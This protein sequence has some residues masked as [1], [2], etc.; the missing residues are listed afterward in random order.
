MNWPGRHSGS[1]AGGVLGR[2]GGAGRPKG[3]W[4]QTVLGGSRLRRRPRAAPESEP[5]NQHWRAALDSPAGF[6]PPTL[7]SSNTRTSEP[8]AGSGARANRAELLP[9]KRPSGR[10]EE[11]DEE[12][13]ETLGSGQR[14]ELEA[15]QIVHLAGEQDNH[16]RNYGYSSNYTN[17]QR[18]HDTAPQSNATLV[19]WPGALASSGGPLLVELDQL[20]QF[21]QTGHPQLSNWGAAFAAGLQ[22][23]RESGS[24]NATTN[25]FDQL[26]TTGGAGSGPILSPFTATAMAGD[27]RELNQLEQS[28]WSLLMSALFFYKAPENQLEINWANFLLALVLIMLMLTTAIGNLFVI[29]AIVIERN[30]RT[31]G[32]YLVLSLAIADLLVACLVMPLAGI[33]QILDRW[34]L[35]ILLCDI[36]TSADVFCCTGKSLWWLLV[37]ACFVG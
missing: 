7:R 18:P 36:W 17:N 28:T 8:T 14:S 15:G 37:I 11:A 10:Q 24:L 35:G 22:G 3:E 29:V 12:L 19:H 9:W 25:H 5:P 1:L 2:A 21:N 32:N 20:D 30:L 31:I 4:A 13:G 23:H 34:T 27:E 33:Y 26:Y 16:N 6:K